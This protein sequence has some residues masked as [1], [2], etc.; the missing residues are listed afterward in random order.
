MYLAAYVSLETGEL[1][2]I[3]NDDFME[4]K[5]LFSFTLSS[6]QIADKLQQEFDDD[7]TVIKIAEYRRCIY[8]IKKLMRI[9]KL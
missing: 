6:I 7:N 2:E 4:S 5:L 3:V 8:R 1:P 9:N